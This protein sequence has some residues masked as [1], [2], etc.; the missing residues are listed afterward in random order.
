MEAKFL[1]VLECYVFRRRNNKNAVGIYPKNYERKRGNR[2][3]NT[4]MPTSYK[5]AFRNIDIE[6][7]QKTGRRLNN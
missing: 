2:S 3:Y 4:N 5:A 1:E 6:D 7:L